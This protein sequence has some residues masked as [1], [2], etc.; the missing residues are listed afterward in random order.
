LGD[1]EFDPVFSE[2]HGPFNVKRYNE[3]HWEIEKKNKLISIFVVELHGV[4][5]ED[6]LKK[7]YA[8]KVNDD[9]ESIEI[10]MPTQPNSYLAYSKDLYAAQK[11]KKLLNDDIKKQREKDR[12]NYK[13]MPQRHK[14]FV[15]INFH[16]RLANDVLSKKGNI[17]KMET[18]VYLGKKPGKKTEEETMEE[19]EEKGKGVGVCDIKWYIAIHAD[20]NEDIDSDDKQEDDSETEDLQREIEGMQISS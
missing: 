13:K 7:R 15:N 20:V 18:T 10:Q 2:R 5:G 1:I 4:Q 14:T 6:V 19:A 11:T 12:Q 17:I 8:A 16:C 3:I 9:N